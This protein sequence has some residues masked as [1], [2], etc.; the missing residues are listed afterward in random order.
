MAVAGGAADT[1]GEARV[2]VRVRVR[3]AREVI[4]MPLSS[5]RVPDA[6]LEVQAMGGWSSRSTH[7]DGLT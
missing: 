3:V 5:R 7:V 2:R 6:G 1:Y 4:R